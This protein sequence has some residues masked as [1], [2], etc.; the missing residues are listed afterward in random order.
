VVAT[1]ILQEA[2]SELHLNGDFSKVRT[3]QI[4]RKGLA[5]GKVKPAEDEVR[6][7]FYFL[8]GDAYIME[9]KFVIVD[10]LS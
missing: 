9:G 10:M 8:T 2:A 4:Q 5:S 6:F 1:V 7:R 3:L